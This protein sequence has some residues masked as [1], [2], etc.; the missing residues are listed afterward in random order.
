MARGLCYKWRPTIGHAAART[1]S[2]RRSL[3]SLD[4]PRAAEAVHAKSLSLQLAL[5]LGHRQ[6]RNRQPGHPRN[7]HRALGTGRRLP[8]L[9]L[10]HRRPLH[11]RRR[12]GNAQ[13]AERHFHFRS[14]RR[15]AQNDGDRSPP[16]DHQSRSRNR[17]RRVRKQRRSAR[18]THRRRQQKAR[19]KKA[20]ELSN[21]P[22]VQKTRRPTRSATFSTAQTAISPSTA[23]TPT[24]RGS[25]TKSSPA[26]TAKPP[27]TTTPI[28]STA[29]A[30]AAPKTSIRP[31][32]KPTSPQRWCTSP[33]RPT[34][35]AAP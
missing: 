24:K 31:S 32:K 17:H 9:G 33:T 10:R 28:S 2:R 34:A 18:R 4:R 8:H 35:S 30:A 16:L 5:D 25:P 11:V 29:S 27:A 3:R 21:N 6:R 12:S 20:C 1:R 15:Q 19:R 7:R 22:W 26:H 23:T 13:H 14:Y